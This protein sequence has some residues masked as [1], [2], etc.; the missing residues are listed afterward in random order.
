MKKIPVL[1]TDENIKY[2][3][4]NN[5]SFSKIINH[6][7]DKIKNDNEIILDQFRS[8]PIRKQNENSKLQKTN[9]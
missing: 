4:D 2:A 1:V 9:Y 6:L 3:N 5:L 8:N 7:L